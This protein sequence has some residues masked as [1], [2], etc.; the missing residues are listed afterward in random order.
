M[1][2]R[3]ALTEL[4]IERGELL[5]PANPPDLDEHDREIIR[6]AEMIYQHWHTK[7]TKRNCVGLAH[8][9]VANYR[10]KIEWSDVDH[11]VGNI[12]SD[13]WGRIIVAK[14]R[15]G[16]KTFKYKGRIDPRAGEMEVEHFKVH[17]LRRLG[18]AVAFWLDGR[19]TEQEGTDGR[20]R[21]DR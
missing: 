12:G 16:N 3:E 4:Y 7:L 1:T 8:D 6:L 18:S 15:V 10:P 2:F 5:D 17:I 20:R 19:R 21:E 14:V 13:V 11:G 9:V